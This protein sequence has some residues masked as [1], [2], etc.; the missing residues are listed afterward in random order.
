MPTT[1]TH[2]CESIFIITHNYLWTSFLSFIFKNFISYLQNVSNDKVFRGQIKMGNIV[3]DKYSP[4]FIPG[5]SQHNAQCFCWSPL[6]K[7]RT[8]TYV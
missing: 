4:C 1:V 6:T 8:V 5:R 2:I 7:I 3:L